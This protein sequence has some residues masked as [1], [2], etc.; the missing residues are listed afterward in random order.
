MKE[1]KFF[2]DYFVKYQY[3]LIALLLPLFLISCVIS[4]D[5]NHRTYLNEVQQYQEYDYTNLNEIANDIWNKN[6]KT[7]SF[8]NIPEDILITDFIYTKENISF[9]AVVN[10]EFNFVSNPTVNVWI[11]QKSNEIEIS[12]LNEKFA[13]KKTILI[14]LSICFGLLAILIPY[15][16]IYLCLLLCY[17]ISN[18]RKKTYCYNK[19]K[20]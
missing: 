11:S 19:R 15:F 16:F 3:R 20:E 8:S 12:S 14:I 9:R 7:L 18:K 5:I 4:Y 6:D 2:C 13:I 17:E 1:K 10:K